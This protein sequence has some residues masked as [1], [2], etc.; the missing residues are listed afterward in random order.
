MIHAAHP[1][2]P[3]PYGG[4]PQHWQYFWLQLKIAE[5]GAQWGNCLCLQLRKG[6]KFEQSLLSDC[7]KLA[8]G[9][10]ISHSFLSGSH[11]QRG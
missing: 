11:K 6:T 9:V 5:Q 7:S 4:L 3:V 8:S 2:P 1:V 10:A